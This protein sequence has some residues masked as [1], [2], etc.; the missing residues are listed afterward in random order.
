MRIE[1][2]ITAELIEEIEKL[3]IEKV[4]V[5]VKVKPR[6][7]MLT[8][9]T[10]KRYVSEVNAEITYISTV[11][12][13]VGMIIDKTFVE[14]LAEQPWVERVYHVPI[15][16]VV[17]KPALGVLPAV[18]GATEITLMESAAH[19]GVDRLKEAGYTGIGIVIA[20]VDTGVEK[21]HPMLV[22]KVILEE[23]WTT[24]PDPSDLYGHGTWVASCLA[25]NRWESPVGVLE[26]MAPG[27]KLINAKVFDKTGKAATDVVMT[28]LEWACSQR[29]QI[30]SNSWGDVAPYEPLRELIRTLKDLYNVIFVFA[31]GNEGPDKFTI[32]YPGGYQEVIGVGSIGVKSPAP[33]AIASFS[34]RGPNVSLDTKPD[35]MAPGGTE[36]ECIIAAGLN[37]GTKCWQGTSMATPHIAGA[38]ALLLEAGFNPK[39]SEIRMYVGATDLLEEG[40][41]SD[42]GYGTP[43]FAKSLALTPRRFFFESWEDGTVD[44]TRTITVT[45]DTTVTATYSEAPP[46]PLGLPI[47]LLGGLG[48][49][50]LTE[51]AK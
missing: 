15:V 49:V 10:I 2:K 35:I 5:L 50:L 13:Y 30:C 6:L 16:S 8:L 39:E 22:D 38:F 27:A 42:S 4:R 23:N 40:K 3:E 19:I 7:T 34:S 1:Q 14:A 43:D 44:P 20:L 31:G 11:S 45:A 41:D 33:N 9:A 25:G 18:V 29:P 12:P 26:G 36:S 47:T 21:T 48:F 37:G 46:I 17:E 28:A 24:E 32:I 51:G